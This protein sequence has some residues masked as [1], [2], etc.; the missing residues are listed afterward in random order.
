M[1]T[2]T[3]VVNNKPLPTVSEFTLMMGHLEE[4]NW[5]PEKPCDYRIGTSSITC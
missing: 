3:F 4:G 2:V 5:L 1:K